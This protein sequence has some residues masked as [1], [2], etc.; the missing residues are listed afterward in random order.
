MEWSEVAEAIKILLESKYHYIKPEKVVMAVKNYETDTEKNYT[1][2]LEGGIVIT[3]T[4]D[5]LTREAKDIYVDV[6]TR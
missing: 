1:L 6:I 3:I 4:I 5:T 2:Y